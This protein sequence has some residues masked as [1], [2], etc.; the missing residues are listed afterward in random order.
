MAR[1]IV[2][3]QVTKNATGSDI[4][5]RPAVLYNAMQHAREWL[6]GETCRRTLNYFVGHYGK[7]TSAGK[8]ATKLVDNTELGSSTS[9]TPTGT[10]TRS[11][12]AIASG[13]R[14]SPTT[15]TTT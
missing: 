12:P 4:P 6:A 1:D 3:L 9:T 2:A 15:T 5:G 13:E 10:S 11:R 8:E 14:T 7:G